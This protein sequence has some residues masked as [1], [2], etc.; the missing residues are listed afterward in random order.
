MRC[1][2]VC[3]CAVK[4]I[5]GYTNRLVKRREGLELAAWLVLLALCLL[6][7]GMT[8]GESLRLSEPPFSHL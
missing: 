7:P 6:T 2:D 3:Q 4:G 5:L 1:D 8:Q